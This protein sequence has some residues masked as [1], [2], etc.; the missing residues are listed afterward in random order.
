MK[1]PTWRIN[2]YQLVILYFFLDRI[3]KHDIEKIDLINRELMLVPILI[4]N[5]NF[6]GR[7]YHWTNDSARGIYINQ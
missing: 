2:W 1:R 6:R 4:A 7:A 5:F 3:H